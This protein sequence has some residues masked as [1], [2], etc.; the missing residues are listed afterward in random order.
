M[1]KAIV[2][3]RECVRELLKRRNRTGPK[4]KY[5]TYTDAD[6][7]PRLKI[8]FLDGDPSQLD[9]RFE[10]DGVWVGDGSKTEG[11]PFEYT[12]PYLFRQLSEHLR[13]YGIVISDD[14]IDRVLAIRETY[15][16]EQP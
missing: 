11:V 7:N 16:Q 13:P 2:Q 3:T 14:A 15:A 12:D 1:D 10:F 4:I 6:R 5:T 9:L 8:D